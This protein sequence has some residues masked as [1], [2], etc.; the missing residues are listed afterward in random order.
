MKNFASSESASHTALQQLQRRLAYTSSCV[1][2]T[3]ADI[4]YAITLYRRATPR[5]RLFAFIKIL[6]KQSNRKHFRD[7]RPVKDS[8]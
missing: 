5:Q 3:A 6:F 2:P 7:R 4:T 8:D 1:F